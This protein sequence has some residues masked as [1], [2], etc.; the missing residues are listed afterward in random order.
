MRSHPFYPI[1]CGFYPF[2]VPGVGTFY[3]FIN[4]LMLRK[5]FDGR[6]L[7]VRKKKPDDKRK[8]HPGIIRRL[9]DR[10]KDGK[11]LPMRNS[12]ASIIK[13]IFA[14]VFIAHSQEI[15]LIEQESLIIS[16]D[17]SKL[18]TWASPYGEKI[19]ECSEKC[20]CTRKL[21]DKEARWVWDSYREQWVYGYT[22]YDY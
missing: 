12:S 7:S 4:L 6:G 16:G 10:L 15:E 13:E 9:A 5:P 18:P 22:Y 20:D 3:D 8:P 1:I 17:G 2:D 21:L 14:I 19:C 11:K